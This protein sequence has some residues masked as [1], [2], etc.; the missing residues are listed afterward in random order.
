MS[1]GYPKPTTPRPDRATL[2]RQLRREEDP[3]CTDGCVVLFRSDTCDHGFPTWLAWLNID[4]LNPP[5]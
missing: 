1:T 5:G 2:G 3:S 4:H